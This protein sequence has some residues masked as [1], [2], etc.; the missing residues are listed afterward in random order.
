MEI[1]KDNSIEYDSQYFR[2]RKP[3][4]VKELERD[5]LGYQEANLGL[6]K[7]NN[8]LSQE[9]K[10]LKRKL[11][12]YESKQLLLEAT[13]RESINLSITLL[14]VLFVPPVAMILL[15]LMGM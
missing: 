6:I 5:A 9:N 8:K 10:E 11:S 14:F 2:N 4:K 3:R 15:F 1:M 13:E 12:E 7:A